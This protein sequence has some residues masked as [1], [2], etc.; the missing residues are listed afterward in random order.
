MKKYLYLL[1]LSLI[2][3]NMHADVQNYKVE[4]GQFDKIKI[5]DNVNVVY[6]CLPDSTGFVQYSGDKEF[7]D[8][9]IIT[10]KSDGTLRIQVS[11]EDVGNPNLPTL[12]VYSDFLTSV[13]NSSAFT[14]VIENPAPCAEFKATQI[15]NGNLAVENVKTNKIIASINT[16]NGTV[17]VS[18]TSQ[19]AVL[20]MVGTGVI[21]AD[22][23]KADDV[24]CKILGSGTI[25]CYPEMN[26]SVKG[27]GS[28]KIYY[29]GDP[30]IKK[31]GGGKLFP[32]P[33]EQVA[34]D[35]DQEEVEVN[36]SD[37][38]NIDIMAETND[39]YDG[40]G[41]YDADDDD[42]EEEETAEEDV[43]Y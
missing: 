9:F 16:G 2:A 13:E 31:A 27:L 17:N 35:D 21:S 7:A 18:G 33:V 10:P 36:V 12:Y 15:G 42:I 29:K 38:V 37:E 25:G 24:E 3:F 8:A 34:L 40:A 22:R 26:L 4:V 19:T 6:R 20:K 30:R 28:T 39:D 14:V 1:L 41:D 43:D 5:Q 11:T 23:L 32:L